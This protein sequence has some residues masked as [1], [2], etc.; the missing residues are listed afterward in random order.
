MIPSVQYFITNNVIHPDLIK[1]IPSGDCNPETT[2]YYSHFHIVDPSVPYDQR[3]HTSVETC[4]RVD[5]A[6]I[7]TRMAAF[8][9]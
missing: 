2:E 6:E 4:P 7:E 5:R 1:L 8:T 3:E 9:P